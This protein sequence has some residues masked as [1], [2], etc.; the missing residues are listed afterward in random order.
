MI[1]NFKEIWSVYILKQRLLVTSSVWQLFQ[2]FLK[3][4]TPWL[5]VRI[6]Y[7]SRV[8]NKSYFDVNMYICKQDF[9][10]K[11]NLWNVVFPE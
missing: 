3:E 1:Y 11:G 4:K 8:H 7:E 6:L 2:P 10:G 5:N 9:K